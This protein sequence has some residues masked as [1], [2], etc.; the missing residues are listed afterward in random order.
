ME[1]IMALDQ[2]TTSSRALII[3]KNGSIK[4]MS[5]QEFPQIFPREQWVEHDP[6]AIWECQKKMLFKVLKNF[7][8]SL[9]EIAAIGIT[10]QRETTVVWDRKTGKPVY[11]AIVWQCRRTVG[12][13]RDLD[14]KGL[15]PLFKKKTGLPLDAYFSGTKIRWILDNVEGAREKAEAGDLLFGTIDT[16]L[17]WK[18][19]AGRVHV[20]D[21][22]NASRTLLF[23]I[24]SCSWDEELLDALQIPASMLPEIKSSSEV[25][26]YTDKETFGEEIPVAGIAGDQQSA[27]FGQMCLEKGDVKNTY[28]TGCFLLM[29]TGEEPIIS[30]KGLITTIALNKEGKT[31]YALEGSIFM[32]GAVMQ[33]L[34]DNLGIIANAPECD[35]W[36][37]KCENNGGVYL[38][39]AF[40]GLGAPYWGMEAR[41]SISGLTRGSDKRHICRAALESIAFRSRDVIDVMKAESGLS[42]HSIKVDGGASR[43]DILMQIQS[44]FTNSEVIRPKSIETTAL[45]AAYLAGLAVGFW[46]SM[47]EISKI[48]KEDRIFVPSMNEE[49]RE[50]LYDGWKEAVKKCLL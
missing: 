16:W 8:V 28:G 29:N 45:G 36:A 32:G 41:A 43:S 34:R 38:V 19:T 37:E 2:G 26:G 21:M 49:T 31:T 30:D 23:N 44:D 27:L 20:T 6:E 1:Y 47:D 5:Q 40:Q 11:N 4:G 39:S 3:E 42:L 14:S 17:I 25:Y 50:T 48:W 22:T 15:A 24:H 13:C 12:I 46:K 33:W 9:K 10:N 7:R 18:L 35:E